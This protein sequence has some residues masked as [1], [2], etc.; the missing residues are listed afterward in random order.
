MKKRFAALLVG[1]MVA[2]TGLMTACGVGT[3]ASSAAPAASSAPASS[4]AA[5][6]AAPQ[7]VVSFK[8]VGNNSSA[9]STEAAKKNCGDY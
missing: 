2:A 9:L 5:D 3:S 4:A 6:S 8:M 7:E 1:L